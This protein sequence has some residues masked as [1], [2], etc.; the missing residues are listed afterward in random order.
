MVCG[1]DIAGQQ[2][3]QDCSCSILGGSG[4]FVLGVPFILQSGKDSWRVF[5]AQYQMFFGIVRF[6]LCT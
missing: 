1:A 6:V 3:R 5:C 4:R 2:I